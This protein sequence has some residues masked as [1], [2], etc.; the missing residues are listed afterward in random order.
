MAEPMCPKCERHIFTTVVYNSGIP[1]RLV[2]CANCGA[3]VG[4]F[5]WTPQ[6]QAL[7]RLEETVAR[8]ETMMNQLIKRLDDS[9][10]A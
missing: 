2:C 7:M 1:L 10:R 3:V 5:E 6:P 8:L 9:D 4:A